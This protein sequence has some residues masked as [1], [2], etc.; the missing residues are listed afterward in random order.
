MVDESMN[1]PHDLA[2]ERFLWLEQQVT[3]LNNNVNILMA[4]L[5]NK[6]GI[7]KEDVG[8]NVEEKSERGSGDQE[9]MEN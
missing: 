5:S 2:K 3:Y 6:L 8:S 9:E 1:K 7:F 4:A